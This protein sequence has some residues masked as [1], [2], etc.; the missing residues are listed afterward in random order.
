M[1]L[2][3]RKIW[4][5]KT[6]WKQSIWIDECPFCINDD[7]LT[8]WQWQHW[9]IRKNKYPYNWLTNHLLLITNRHIEHTKELNNDELLE[10]KKAENFLYDYYKWIDYFS[11]IRQTNWW[12]SIKHIHYHYIPWTLYSSDVEK[13]LK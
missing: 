4:D 7:W 8:L 6:K 9:N 10:I 12:K 1:K 13:I 2:F 5:E 11:L 3:D